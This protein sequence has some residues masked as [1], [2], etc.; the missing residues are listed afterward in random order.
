[1]VLNVAFK[2]YIF[3]KTTRTNV[4]CS[5]LSPSA[6]TASTRRAR[7]ASPRKPST[8]PTSPSSWP[9]STR[10]P[11]AS[12]TFPA[13]QA[14]RPQLPDGPRPAQAARGAVGGQRGRVQLCAPQPDRGAA[15]VR[16]DEEGARLPRGEDPARKGNPAPTQEEIEKLG[17]FRSEYEEKIG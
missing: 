9:R 11:A 17:I 2:S 16:R 5:P 6:C 13:T 1:M 4:R 14:R 15:Q 12:S 7:C 8:T 10:S 3:M